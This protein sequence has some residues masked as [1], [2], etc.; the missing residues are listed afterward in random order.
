[1]T[2][3]M[4]AS[5][6]S[7]TSVEIG[8]S[9][10]DKPVVF[11][12]PD[13]KLPQIQARISYTGT[14]R[15]KGRWEIV[16]PGEDPPSVNDLLTEATLP[17]ESRSSQRRYTQ[18]SRFNVFLPAGGDYTLAGPDGDALPRTVAGEYLLLLR[19]E[20]SE[21]DSNASDLSAVGA[22]S[23]VVYSGAV[24]GF[25]MPALHYFVSSSAGA[26]AGAIS[27]LAPVDNKS[28]SP[29]EQIDFAWADTPNAVVFKLQIETSDAKP[30]FSALLPAGAGTYRA[31][32]WLRERAGA[33]NLRWR[34]SAI[35]GDGQSIGESSWRS[36][37]FDSLN[38]IRSAAP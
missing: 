16:M 17:I 2:G 3:G 30:V 5:P 7:L 24:A 35:D 32:S 6:F 12:K 19:I 20:A 11:A 37:R 31:P 23:G 28:F 22:G 1:M 9:G 33:A 36:L 29:G 8:F 14:G 13:E 27:Q 18:L 34:V 38:L 21:N 10:V 26:P 25:P 4:S 15:L